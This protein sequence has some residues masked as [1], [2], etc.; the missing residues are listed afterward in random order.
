MTSSGSGGGGSNAACPYRSYIWTARTPGS[1]TP[2]VLHARIE[3]SS[4]GLLSYEETRLGGRRIEAVHPDA[5]D[6]PACERIARAREYLPDGT[7]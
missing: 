2:S 6:V 5:A 4:I 3:I 1:Y 7:S